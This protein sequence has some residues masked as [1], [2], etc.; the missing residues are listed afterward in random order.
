[1]LST[2]LKKVERNFWYRGFPN[3]KNPKEKSHPS[4]QMALSKSKF[5]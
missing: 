3:E 4:K 5:D 2:M 1:M